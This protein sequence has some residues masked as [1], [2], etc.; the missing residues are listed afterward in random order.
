[1]LDLGL[2][3]KTRQSRDGIS[4]KITLGELILIAKTKRQSWEV[5]FYVYTTSQ[6]SYCNFK[7]ESFHM[8]VED[9]LLTKNSI[10]SEVEVYMRKDTGIHKFQYLYGR[11]LLYASRTIPVWTAF[12]A[13]IVKLA[14]GNS[15]L[16]L[17]EHGWDRNKERH[18]LLFDSMDD[19]FKRFA[20][21]DLQEG[22]KRHWFSRVL[23]RILKEPDDI[24]GIWELNSLF[25]VEYFLEG[26][27]VGRGAFWYVYCLRRSMPP[28]EFI[29][30][31]MEYSYK[32]RRLLDQG[33]FDPEALQGDNIVAHPDVETFIFK[34]FTSARLCVST[35]GK[36]VSQKIFDL[37]RQ[38]GIAMESKPGDIDL[39]SLNHL[40]ECSCFRIYKPWRR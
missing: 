31:L 38:T 6:H 7:E 8:S 32:F 16:A 4:I 21:I 33:I 37:S 26:D 10:P 12:D 34:D 11:H 23:L 19:S 15:S 2:I 17:I 29:P 27:G 40:F 28:D 22:K 1:M 36:T 13:K 35:S 5:V 30:L 3:R 24:V 18:R 14:T 9:T 25:F 20:V 39:T